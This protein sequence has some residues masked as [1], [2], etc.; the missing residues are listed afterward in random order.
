M[1]PGS[2]N[3]IG[4]EVNQLIQDGKL[5]TVLRPQMRVE[6]METLKIGIVPGISLNR[7]NE[8]FSSFIRLIYEPKQ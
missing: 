3:F 7:D 4:L 2:S 5:N 1:I 6:V 8:R